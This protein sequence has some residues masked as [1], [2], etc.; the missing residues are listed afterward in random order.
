MKTNRRDFFQTMG[1]GAAGFGLATTLPLAS[2]AAPATQAAADDDEQ[3][4][5][6]GDDIALANTQ[7]GKVKGYVL[8]GINYFLG[9]PYGA[10]TSSK[11]RFMP[12][13]KPEPWDDVFPA[14]WWGNSAPQNIDGQYSNKYSAF[15]DHWNYDDISEDCLRLNV[16]TPGIADGKKRP[17]LV[18]FHGGGFTAG[19]GIEQDGYNGENISRKGNIVFVSLNHRLGP[20]GFSNLAGVGGDKFAD[21]G[22]VGILDLVAA[23]EWVR[24]N[25]E[26]FGGDPGNVTIMGQSGGGGK[27]KAITGTPKA[28]GLFHKAVVL[29]GFIRLW[30]EKDTTE[31]VGEYILKEAGIS[32]NEIEKLQQMPWQEYYALANRAMAKF[33]QETGT[34]M[35]MG[36]FVPVVGTDLIPEEPYFPKA[37]PLIEDIPMIFSSTTEEMSP[38]RTN[39]ELENITLEEVIEQVKVRAGFE[40]GLGDKA[41]KVVHAYAKAFPDKRPVEIW[42]LV[43]ASRRGNVALADSKSKQK[44]PVYMAWFGWQPPLFNKRMRAFHCLDIS[45]WFN[46]TDVMYTHTGGGKRPRELSN[47]IAGSL[48]QFMKTGD[49]NGGGLP[50]WPRYTSE[51]GEV[52][53]L[54]DVCEVKNDP[55]RE[56]RKLL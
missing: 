22:N 31:K 21:S 6:I 7:Y 12:P 26:N 52:M 49:P 2:C 37:T 32:K 14:V 17:V 9:I 13:Q 18:W 54:N 45:F 48:I 29:S 30:G 56:A 15:V 34:E 8:R 5:F 11:N 51:K 46:N 43:S 41:E 10:P 35:G 47:K 1:A 3:I 50:E 53:I 42:A 55:D 40:P 27:V 24:D 38:S 36:G 25:I 16:F 44:A 20:M 4:L 28:K 23:L 19:N 33:A 39:P